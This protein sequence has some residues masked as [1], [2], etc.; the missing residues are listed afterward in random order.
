MI[1][2]T[3]GWRHD[4]R[5]NH[6]LNQP[7]NFL[8]AFLVRS[9]NFL[10]N[11]KIVNFEKKFRRK[12]IFSRLNNLKAKIPSQGQNFYFQKSLLLSKM[13]GYKLCGL[14]FSNF[15]AKFTGAITGCT[16]VGGKYW[17]NCA[18]TF[19]RV[20]FA[21]RHQK[22]WSSKNLQNFV[23]SKF[24]CETTLRHVKV[25]DFAFLF[26]LVANIQPRYRSKLSNMVLLF[27]YTVCIGR[28]RIKSKTILKGVTNVFKPPS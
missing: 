15:T 25:A 3:A 11:Q 20:F 12:S 5:L 16:S 18:A 22:S 9:S 14:K 19:A 2:C 1:I 23:F 4:S 28:I 6:W 13:P 17:P 8:F 26:W 24:S 10:P 27:A 7:H 21:C